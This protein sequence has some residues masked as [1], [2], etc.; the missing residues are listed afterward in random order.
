MKILADPKPEYF[1][2]PENYLTNRMYRRAIRIFFEPRIVG[3]MT[4]TQIRLSQVY[5]EEF[6]LT[7]LPQYLV[8][9]FSNSNSMELHFWGSEP[10]PKIS[11]LVGPGVEKIGCIGFNAGWGFCSQCL[12]RRN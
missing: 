6:S 12:A 8:I 7:E 9:R 3:L 11:H 10:E 2:G 1:V 4:R 5:R